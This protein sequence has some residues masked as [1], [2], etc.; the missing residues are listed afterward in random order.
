MCP[1]TKSDD[2][3]RLGRWTAGRSRGTQQQHGSGL[4]CGRGWPVTKQVS[5]RVSPSR[6]VYTRSEYRSSSML[7]ARPEWTILTVGGAVKPVEKN[8]ISKA[9]VHAVPCPPPS[10][11]SIHHRPREAP[12]NFLSSYECQT[13]LSEETT[14]HSA[15]HIETRDIPMHIDAVGF[16]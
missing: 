14:L 10:I 11:N 3:N 16:V 1:P 5:S 4:T 9:F 6:M 8:L 12:Y 15:L 2:P 13:R 7:H